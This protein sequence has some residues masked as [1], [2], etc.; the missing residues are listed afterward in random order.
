MENTISSASRP[1]RKRRQRKPA[2]VERPHFKRPTTMALAF[3][4][5]LTKLGVVVPE[6]AR[7]PTRKE[8]EW[9]ASKRS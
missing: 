3:E 7:R 9:R 5:A 8:F 6:D 2:V 1:P 4:A